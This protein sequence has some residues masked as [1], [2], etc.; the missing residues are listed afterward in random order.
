VHRSWTV[1][2]QLA[3]PDEASMRSLQVVVGGELA[4]DGLQ[5]TAFRLTI[6]VEAFLAKG[7]APSVLLQHSPL[8]PGPTVQV[9]L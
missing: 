9:A 6:L 1:V 4:E 5:V 3:P 8:A 2:H 7:C